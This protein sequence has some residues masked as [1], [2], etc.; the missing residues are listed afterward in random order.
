MPTSDLATA[1]PPASPVFRVGFEPEPWAWP[2]WRYATDGRFN[3]RWDDSQ[4]IFRTIYAGDTLFAC[5]VEVLAALRADPQL[6]DALAEIEVD[7]LD[8]DAYPNLPAGRVPYSWLEPRRAASAVLIGAFCDVTAADSIAALRPHFI[9]RALVSHRPDFDAALLKDAGA[10]RITQQVASHIFATSRCDGIFF[11]SRHGD[12][13]RLWA[14]FERPDDPEVSPHLT[15][16]EQHPL[17]PD[18]PDLTS[19][20]AHLGLTWESA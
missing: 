7:P 18:D 20:L 14:I 13:L 2:D 12:D 6:V 17:S 19:A 10:R 4:G 16:L 5:L 15:Q 3:G 11:G 8:A 1:S 9:A